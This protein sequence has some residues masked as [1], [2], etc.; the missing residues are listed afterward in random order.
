MSSNNDRSVQSLDRSLDILEVLA[1]SRN[2]YGVTEI[3]NLTGLHKSTVHRLL[4]TLMSRGYVAK[5]MDN[6]RYLLG[7]R[8][9]LLSSAILDRMDLR[10]VAKPYIEKLCNKTTEVVHLTVLD[11][12]E[13]V[14]VDKVE[15]PEKNVRMNS[16]IGKR[17]PIY[18]TSGGKAL[19]S[20]LPEDKV[21]EILRSVEM[22]KLT[23]N[24]I[25]SIEEYKKNLLEVRRNGYAVDEIE[26]EEGIR[27]IAAP[28]KD[29]HGDVVAAVSITGTV[30]QVTK[31]RIPE[32]SKD[33]LETVKGISYML[34]Y[35]E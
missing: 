24:T 18:S 31:E 15:Y 23:P 20:Q 12:N 29:I 4:G 10:S 19:L 17:I 33:L 3:A 8:V 16:Q 22:K 1:G 35:H 21:D 34:G 13:A 9:L 25:T 7:M 26:N 28:V 6:N 32:L 30:M 11:G 5:D 27:C 2:G 14:Y